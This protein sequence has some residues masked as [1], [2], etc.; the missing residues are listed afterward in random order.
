M[1]GKV[2]GP[3][4]STAAAAR[5]SPVFS[6]PQHCTV[7]WAAPEGTDNT[8]ALAACPG[9]TVTAQ[10]H[11]PVSA[12]DLQDRTDA[13]QLTTVH[14]TCVFVPAAPTPAGECA[15]SVQVT[16]AWAGA[17]TT[18]ACLAL[19]QGAQPELSV[20]LCGTNIAKCAKARGV[21]HVVLDLVM[22]MSELIGA[23]ILDGSG[24]L[25]PAR[26]PRL[27]P[28]AAGAAAPVESAW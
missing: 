15:W 16:L 14:Q 19:Q 25:V 22:K 7:L 21:P 27:V 11:T 8:E 2:M 17:S 4:V 12:K 6:G 26:L 28:G 9:A 5:S 10:V 3:G 20:T 23:N 13:V 1:Q 18:D 24:A